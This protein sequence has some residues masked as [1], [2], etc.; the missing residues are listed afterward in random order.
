M[1]I[2]YNDRALPLYGHPDLR[3]LTV[4]RFNAEHE[5]CVEFIKKAVAESTAQHIV[6]ATH[7]VPCWA[8]QSEDFEGSRINGAFVTELG[9]FIEGSRIDYWV[10]GHSPLNI[11]RTIGNTRCVTNQL[12]YVYKNEHDSFRNNSSFEI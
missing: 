11:E 3:V 10:Y 6:V 7:H 4:Q 12:G 2:A 8:L 1:Q 5:R 9:D